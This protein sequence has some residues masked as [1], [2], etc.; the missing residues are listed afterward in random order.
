MA[1]VSVQLFMPL[2]LQ[3]FRK[4]ADVGSSLIKLLALLLWNVASATIDAIGMPCRL[5]AGIQL[6][7]KSRRS[8]ISRHKEF[9]LACQHN[10]HNCGGRTDGRMNSSVFTLSCLLELVLVA[11]QPPDAVMHL[12]GPPES[13]PLPGLRPAIDR[14]SRELSFR[15]YVCCYR[16]TPD[17]A[18][19]E[20]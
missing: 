10:K 14:S 19:V 17:V 8:S 9:K 3:L 20:R 12:Q 2:S 16:D 6:A 13:R 1:K 11:G 5:H 15:L 4:Q 7:C 18:G